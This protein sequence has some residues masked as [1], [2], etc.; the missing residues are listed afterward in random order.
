MQAPLFGVGLTMFLIFAGLSSTQFHSYLFESKGL[1]GLQVGFLLM[2]GQGA[3]ILSPFLQV[4]IIR[5]FGGPRIPLVIM[6]AGAA[7]TLALLPHMRG[8]H[9]FLALF[10]V[11]S[12]CA[13]SIFPLNAA[14]TL[15]AMRDRGHGTFFRLRTL[16]T[17]GFLLGCLISVGYPHL[18][19]LPLLYKGFSIALLLALVVVA[20][21]SRRH[22]PGSREEP[23]SAAKSAPHV[24]GVPGFRKALSLLA[25]PMTLRLLLVL[26]LMNFANAMATG[27]QANYLVHRWH[28][29]QRTISLAWVVS[30]GCEAPLMLLCARVLNRYGLRYVL[31][32]GIL[33]TL[34]KLVGL[35]SA[36]SLWQ[37]YLALTMHGCFF[38]GALTGFSVYLDRKYHRRETPTLQALAGV[39]YGGI[40]SA[41]AGLAVGWVWHA[42]S[43]RAVYL[44][45][46]SIAVPVALYGVY[47]LRGPEEALWGQSRDKNVL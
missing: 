11:F 27:V 7:V 28:E 20:W 40:P 42:V 33:G 21:E 17:L 15:E 34:V 36:G 6:M 44:L 16:G 30:T 39:F 24:F 45:S 13:A 9:S 31:G 8:F 3:A 23:T 25:E 12:F 19:E 14:C 41:L 38:S 46:G 43:L 2:A 4:A 47:L 37:F 26:G 5:R 29:G 32:L 35:A 10:P 22:D 18:S 1:G